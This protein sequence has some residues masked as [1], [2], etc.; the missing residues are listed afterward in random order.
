M[1]LSKNLVGRLKYRN[2]IE[3]LHSSL[4]QE[5]IN[6]RKKKK[7]EIEKGTYKYY[8]PG[9]GIQFSTNLQKTN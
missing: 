7:K 3:N 1:H 8:L 6:K 5:K 4:N 9:A 2:S